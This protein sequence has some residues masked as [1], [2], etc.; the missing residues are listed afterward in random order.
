M[1]KKDMIECL[2][3]YYCD[4]NK[5]K[6]AQLLGLKPQT[7]SG[8]LARDTFDAE[9]VYRSLEGISADWLLSNGEMGEMVRTSQSENTS[10][11]PS[12]ELIRLRAENELLRELVGLRK[13]ETPPRAV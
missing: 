7:I 10:A 9:L 12:V 3:N 4:G 1:N 13:K 5:A 2:V 8:W 6:F 11:S